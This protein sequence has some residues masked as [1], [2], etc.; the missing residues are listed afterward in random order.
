M[1]RSGLLVR[2]EAA[3]TLL[4]EEQHFANGIGA[5][6]PPPQGRDRGGGRPTLLVGGLCSAGALL[7]EGEAAAAA[8]ALEVGRLVLGLG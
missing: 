6:P 3:G 1:P 8:A 7:V 2:E 4:W 5:D